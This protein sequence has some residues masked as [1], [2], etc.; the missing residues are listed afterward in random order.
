MHLLAFIPHRDVFP[1]LR[2]YQRVLFAGGVEGAYSFP[3]AAPLALLSRPLSAAA[4]KTLAGALRE[5]SLA[6]GRDGKFRSGPAVVQDLP[7]L[8]GSI[9]ALLGIELDGLPGT[10][11]PEQAGAE[12]LYR[13]PR[14]ALCT[15]L[16]LNTVPPQDSIP[17]VFSF[18]AAALA[19]ID[20]SFRPISA[21]GSIRGYTA[22]WE[23]G[24]LVWLPKL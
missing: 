24:P 13:F 5:E 1:V 19:N 20:L 17:P 4:L 11:A 10:A 3:P 9:R 15:A 8:F 6:G 23:T 7:E 18:R 21:A 2:A 14:P 12:V 22:E 16:I